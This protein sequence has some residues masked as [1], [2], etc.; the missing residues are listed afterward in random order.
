MTIHEVIIKYIDCNKE[1]AI[2]QA[3]P[4]AASWYKG[5][6]IEV[7]LSNKANGDSKI[8]CLQEAQI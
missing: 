5:S 4:H 7:V 8:D 3:V 1:K 6:C 2:I